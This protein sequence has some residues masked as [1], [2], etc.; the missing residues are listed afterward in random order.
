MRTSP[1]FFALK[2]CG[3]ALSVC[4]LFPAQSVASDLYWY[5]DFVDIVHEYWTEHAPDT[6]L[7]GSGSW[8]T[9][10]PTKFGDGPNT[11]A[12]LVW[13]AGFWDGNGDTAIFAGDVAGTVTLVGAGSDDAQRYIYANA[14]DFRTDGYVIEANS[15]GRGSAYHTQLVLVQPSG[16]A[17]PRIA[18]STGIVA[19][20]NAAIVPY[21]NPEYARSGLIKSGGGTLNLGGANTYTGS[22]RVSEGSL[23]IS[24]AGSLAAGTAITVAS[25]ATLS[26]AGTI[27]GA[28]TV[29]SGGSLFNDGGR[30]VGAVDVAGSLY[31]TGRVGAVTLADGG[32]IGAGNNGDIGTLNT[33]ALTLNG[34]TY[35]FFDFEADGS[36]DRLDID[37][38]L[39][40]GAA[41][42]VSVL[43]NSST[44]DG[45][46]DGQW[47][48][49]DT[50][51]DLSGLNLSSFT[52][53]DGNLPSYAG[54]FSIGLNAQ[55][56]SELML[57]YTA[58]PEP[59]TYALFF[60]V[61]TLGMVV[62]RRWRAR[63]R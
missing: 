21:T 30:T 8:S 27:A 24:S 36:S 41:A 4:W 42:S 6:V 28:V 29:N 18:V 37:G 38:G 40:L 59:Q 56:S 50:T 55:D 54:T 35:Y 7:G 31:G 47:T 51:A 25:G 61:G 53:Q 43:L 32:T 60:G 49:L 23:R 9:G 34:D 17:A 44:F 2:S 22:T 13:G 15:Y 52:M 63:R 16:A 11:T 48:L 19:T 39:T 1:T 14:L 33:G 46:T 10:Y 3:V 26:N 20:I 5:G 12:W 45:R 58:I 62:M 57:T